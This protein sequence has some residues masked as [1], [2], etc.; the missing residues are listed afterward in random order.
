M[1]TRRIWMFRHAE[2]LSNAGGRT[3][4]VTRIPLTQRGISQALA[5]AGSHAEAPAVIVNSPFLRSAQTAAPSAARFAD[6]D[7]HAWPIQEFTYLEPSTCIGTYWMDR[8]PRVDAYWARL[9]PAHRDGPGAESFMDLMERTRWLLNHIVHAELEPLIMVVGHGM[10]MQLAAIQ[11]ETPDIAPL[12]AMRLFHQRQEATPYANCERLRL[13]V[14][15]GIV[16][17]DGRG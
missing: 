4:D 15:D 11:C 5:L 3:D 16:R 2:S 14:A 1:E 8:K 9:D 10:F 13:R 7:R 6:A 12:D 17:A